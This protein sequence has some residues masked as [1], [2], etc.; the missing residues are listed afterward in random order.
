MRPGHGMGRPWIGAG[1]PRQGMDP[2]GSS[3]NHLG[4]SALHRSSALNLFHPEP[5]SAC[6]AKPPE[7][8]ERVSWCRVQS[9]LTLS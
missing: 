4:P 7:K 8:T 3:V 6:W 9:R 2:A 5:P 1:D